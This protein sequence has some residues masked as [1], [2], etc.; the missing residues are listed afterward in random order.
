[1]VGWWK[2]QSKA[3]KIVLVTAVFLAI[4]FGLADYS[5]TGRR[6]ERAKA[7]SANGAP[8]SAVPVRALEE[9]KSRGPFS[10]HTYSVDYAFVD[11][12]GHKWEGSAELSA[13][14]FERLTDPANTK[15]IRADARLE[16]VYNKADPKDN[17]LKRHF[18]G[19][20]EPNLAVSLITG[21]LVIGILLGLGTLAW[22]FAYAPRKPAG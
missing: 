2:R 1:M 5:G 6:A 22:R 14:E 20:R 4:L 8:A 21:F 15:G 7:M 12:G 19:Q 16:V 13:E 17:G 10:S 9:R 3:R 11:A 18:D